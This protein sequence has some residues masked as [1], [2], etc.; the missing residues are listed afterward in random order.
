MPVP[1]RT[2]SDPNSSADINEL[3]DQITG[4]LGFEFIS[5][6]ANVA[7]TSANANT[8][9]YYD[10]GADIDITLDDSFLEGNFV[11]IHFSK[12]A[13]KATFKSDDG[14]TLFFGIPGS[15]QT[16]AAV[17]DA[18]T[19]ATHWMTMAAGGGWVDSLTVAGDFSS[20]FN[21]ASSI[22]SKCRRNMG[23]L[24]WRIDFTI[25]AIPAA[26][27]PTIANPFGLAID[28]LSINDRPY[29][30]DWYLLT[31][32]GTPATNIFTGATFQ[33]VL[34]YDGANAD[35][36]QMCVSS[37]SNN[38]EQLL[39][40]LFGSGSGSYSLKLDFPI[41]GWSIN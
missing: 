40:N 32:N 36:V 23:N 5:T 21:T 30:G 16:I 41:S 27:M 20:A 4:G 28:I 7:L 34:I 35:S 38:F 19:D 14:D 3:Q 13:Y 24:E 9:L 18:P 1:N 15:W 22:S 2:S 11:E 29:L 31:N 26:S 6:S 17:Q 33:G 39:F 10:L 37:V 8:K 12:S 25:G